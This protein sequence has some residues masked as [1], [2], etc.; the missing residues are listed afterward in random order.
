M[1]IEVP[2]RHHGREYFFDYDS[3]G[4]LLEKP[5]FYERHYDAKTLRDRLMSPEGLKL[6]GVL[7]QGER[8]AIDRWRPTGRLPRILRTDHF[9][10]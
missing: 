5:E 2:Y 8:Y 7:Y 1:I 6:L 9:A 10:S 3:K 4:T